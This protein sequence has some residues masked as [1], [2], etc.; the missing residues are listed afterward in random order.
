M[1]KA[2]ANATTSNAKGDIVVGTGSTTAAPLTVGTDGYMLYADSTATTG[3]KWAAAPAAG[4][5]TLISRQTPSASTGLSFTSIPATY[6]DLMLRWVGAY[7]SDTA[8][9]FDVR[10]NAATSLYGSYAIQGTSSAGAG[11]TSNETASNA[12][13]FVSAQSRTNTSTQLGSF[14][15]GTYKIANYANTTYAKYYDFNIGYYSSD[16]GNPRLYLGTGVYYTTSAITSVDIVRLGGT[17]TFSVFA[18]GY[19]ELWGI[20]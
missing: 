20:N 7:T 9:E 14:G 13:F 12:G 15:K 8:T 5:M 6:T 2:R 10:F 16:A 18:N 17:G 19:V 11:V 4:S 3:I 1:T